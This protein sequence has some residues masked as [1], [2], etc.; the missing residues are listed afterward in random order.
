VCVPSPQFAARL[1]EK[2]ICLFFVVCD[3][4]PSFK[5]AQIHRRA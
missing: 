1:R 5:L 4:A 2:K 3:D